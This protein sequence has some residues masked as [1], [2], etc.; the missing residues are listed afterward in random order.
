[1]KNQ[2]VKLTD[3]RQKCDSLYFFFV[4]GNAYVFRANGTVAYC[5]HMSDIYVIRVRHMS[6][7]QVF[8]SSVRVSSLHTECVHTMYIPIVR[9]CKTYMLKA[10]GV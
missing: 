2:Q 5:E 9:M 1:V 6:V 3:Y 10:Y 8:T 4:G 7:R